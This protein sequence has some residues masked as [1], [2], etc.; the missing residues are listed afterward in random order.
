MR[1]LGDISLNEW[2]GLVANMKE[3]YDESQ[4]FDDLGQCICVNGNGS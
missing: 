4:H 2:H 1:M 3:I